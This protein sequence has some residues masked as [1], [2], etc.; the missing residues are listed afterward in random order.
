MRD[1]EYQLMFSVEPS[2]WWFLSRRLFVNS[3]LTRLLPSATSQPL[4]LADIGAGTGGMAAF[5]SRYGNVT[6]IEPNAHARKLASERAIFL[7]SGSAEHSTLASESMD[8]VCLFDVLYHRGVNEQQALAEAYR[9]VKP[10][11]LLV[12]TDC[13]LPWLAGPHDEAMAG[14]ERYVRS[15]LAAKFIKAGFAIRSSSYTFFLVFPLVAI[16]RLH[17]RWRPRGV[18]HSD[19]SAVHPIVNAAL[20]ALGRAEAWLLARMRLP[21]GSSLLVVAQK[22]LAENG[23]P[24]CGQS[25]QAQ[26]EDTE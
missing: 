15:Q 21:W 19:V 4:A 22:P 23:G 20:L 1:D 10:G 6:G 25:P 26:R 12:V 11:G 24:S 7:R 9:I 16:K 5:L 8:V 18:D 13:A 14:R 2:H 17:D 3:V